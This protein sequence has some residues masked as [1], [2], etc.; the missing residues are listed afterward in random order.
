MNLQKLQQMEDALSTMLGE[1]VHLAGG[2]VRDV[3]YN[4]TPKDYDA[5]ICTSG[6]YDEA[7]ATV[8][9]FSRIL[10]IL[11]FPSEV[12]QAYGVN[13]GES[14][15]PGDFRETFLACIKTKLPFGDVDILLSKAANMDEHIALHDCNMNMVYLDSNDPSGYAGIRQPVSCLRFRDGICQE[16]IDYI[17]NKVRGYL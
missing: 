2:C 14:I 4:R 3:L 10:S 6:D 17:T 8:V 13:N 9:R 12:Y 1:Q 7:F 11:G 15:R 16:R 5:I